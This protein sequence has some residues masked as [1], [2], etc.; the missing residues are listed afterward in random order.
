MVVQAGFGSLRQLCVRAR[1]NQCED[2]NETADWSASAQVF[3]VVW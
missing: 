2:G 3:V 1:E